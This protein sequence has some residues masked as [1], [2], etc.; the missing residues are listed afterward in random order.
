[1]LEKVYYGNSL[2][3][4]SISLLI[5]AGG[6][7]LN[8]ILLLINRV[9]VQRITKKSKTRYD[10]IFFDAL[11]KPL[12]FGVMLA[13]VWVA[14]ERLNLGAKAHEFTARSCHI[15]VTLNVTWFIAR[16][17]VALVEE[18][19]F[20]EGGGLRKKDTRLNRHLFPVVKRSLLVLIWLIGGVTALGGAGVEVRSL[21]GTL[22]IG[23]LAFALASQD[24]VKNMLGGITV[25]IDRPFRLGDIIRFD[26]TEGTV[27]DIGLRST[28]IRTYDRQLVVI[29]NSRLMDVSVINI[30]QEP[31][32]RVV[33]TLGLTYD[34]RCE[35]MEYALTLLKRIPRAVPEVSDRDLV[36]TF[37]D[38]GDSA[39]LITFIYFIRK[40]ADIRETVSKVNFEILRTFSAAGLNFAFPTQTVYLEGNK[41]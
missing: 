41:A 16:T 7:V 15:L 36:A 21:W 18:S 23:G 10:D 30:T 13:A 34:T 1:M 35:Q 17:V 40:P 22:G 9:V 25:F 26:A 3:D 32:R 5:I 11:K 4:W 27:E 38:Y 33:L 39:M 14:C 24:T 37:S 12:L 8:Q 20:R 19:F 31:A 28:R 6:L 29:P 2:E